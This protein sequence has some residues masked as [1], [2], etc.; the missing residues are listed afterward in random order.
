MTTARQSYDPYKL[1]DEVTTL[2]RERGLDPEL[3]RGRAG[4]ALG[5]AGMLLRALGVQ[6]L[7]DAFDSFQRTGSRV[8]SEE[9]GLS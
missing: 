3:P 6:P 2:L 7:M 9:D 1:I 5:G 4:E 8:W